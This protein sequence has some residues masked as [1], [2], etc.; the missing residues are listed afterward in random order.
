VI[1]VDDGERAMHH[2]DLVSAGT[3]P[4][5][6][7]VLLDLRLP[8]VDGLEIL[9]RIKSSPALRPIPVVV[10]TTS[11]AARDVRDA[12]S[13]YA[14]SYLVKPDDDVAIG[15]LLDELSHYW[16]DLNERIP[17]CEPPRGPARRR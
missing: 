14:N 11:A 5:P 15:S 7:L 4:V 8:R 16:L 6:A 9:Q 2:L 10:F 1:H 17:S 13:R 12:A 3:S